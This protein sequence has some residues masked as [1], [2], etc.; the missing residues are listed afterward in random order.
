M[1]SVCTN[2]YTRKIFVNI[3]EHGMSM[4]EAVVAVLLALEVGLGTGGA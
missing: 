2:S 4:F 1:R 3:A